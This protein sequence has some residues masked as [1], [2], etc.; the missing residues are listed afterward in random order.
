MSISPSV[1]TRTFCA[2]LN[3]EDVNYKPKAEQE[4]WIYHLGIKISNRIDR[5]TETDSES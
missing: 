3:P 5:D 1:V 2:D 4:F